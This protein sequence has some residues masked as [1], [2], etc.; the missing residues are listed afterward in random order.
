MVDDN[1]V[2]SV[3]DAPSRSAPRDAAVRVPELTDEEKAAPFFAD[4]SDESAGRVLKYVEALFVKNARELERLPDEGMGVSATTT[5]A[6][7]LVR[8]CIEMDAE[9]LTLDLGDASIDEAAVGDWRVIVT[10]AARSERED[11]QRAEASHPNPN[12][13]TE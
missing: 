9:T 10:K 7:F 3:A 4:L 13:E 11:T 1:E 6:L 12:T 8:H 2:A 5:A